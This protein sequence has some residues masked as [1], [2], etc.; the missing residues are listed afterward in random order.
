MCPDISPLH[1]EPGQ[2]RLE[3][4]RPAY[5]GWQQRRVQAYA[6]PAASTSPRPLAPDSA[7]ARLALPL[8]EL[9]V[10]DKRLPPR[11]SAAVGIPCYK[12][13]DFHLNRLRQ[14][15][16]GSLA[17]HCCEGIHSRERWMGKGKRSMFLYGVFT[18]AE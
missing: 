16:L 18:P 4:V 13:R 8:G 15:P 2:Q 17:S 1:G 6:S 9:A 3:T 5:G 12:H 14:K 10:A 11:A 7:N